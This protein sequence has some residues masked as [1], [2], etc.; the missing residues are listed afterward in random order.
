MHTYLC[1]FNEKKTLQQKQKYDPIQDKDYDEDR[2]RP[3]LVLAIKSSVHE[4]TDDQTRVLLPLN[5]IIS[6]FLVP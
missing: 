3:I 5:K 4:N 1:A 2:D 6:P